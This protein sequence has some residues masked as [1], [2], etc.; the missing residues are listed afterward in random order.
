MKTDDFILIA[1]TMTNGYGI[2]ADDL[3]QVYLI[4][5]PFTFHGKM[6]L[7][8]E[9]IESTI[10]HLGFTRL[11]ETY[12]SWEEIFGRLRQ[13]AWE[14]RRQ[15]GDTRPEQITDEDRKAFFRTIPRGLLS[16]PIQKM[17]DYLE[18]GKFAQAIFVGAALLENPNLDGD[19]RL[20]VESLYQQA[21]IQKEAVLSRWKHLERDKLPIRNTS[22][23]L[24]V[25]LTPSAA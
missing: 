22:L 17:E 15:A 18:A 12:R 7:P 23:H 4:K 16:S 2:V 9:H 5:P 8:Y 20:R 6:H 14:A 25:L 24:G 1:A 11:N 19:D 13:I 21:T 10:A 3:G